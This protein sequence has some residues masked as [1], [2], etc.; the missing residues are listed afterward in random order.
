MTPN[1]LI[2][3]PA[4]IRIVTKI[5]G[6]WQ[7][8]LETDWSL[9]RS[10]TT[11]VTSHGLASSLLN[12]L[13]SSSA[14]PPRC[15]GQPRVFA[16]RGAQQKSRHPRWA[17]SPRAQSRPPRVASRREPGNINVIVARLNAARRSGVR[18]P[19]LAQPH[20]GKHPRA[21]SFNAPS[22]R[23]CV[24]DRTHRT[25]GSTVPRSLG[26]RDRD[27]LPN[28]LMQ[29]RVSRH[30]SR[31]KQLADPS[32]VRPSPGSQPIVACTPKPPKIP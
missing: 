20:V 32:Q 10:D 8:G 15:G 4:W 6:P 23:A 28:Y 19:Y 29:K 13:N 7:C 18:V 14:H 22:M 5:T 24:W 30:P 26:L 11:N 16:R 27:G 31:E 12:K 25:Q 17:A 21:P 2:F 3:R 1:V 9:E